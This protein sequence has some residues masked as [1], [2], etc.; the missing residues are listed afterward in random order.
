MQTPRGCPGGGTYWLKGWRKQ[1][2]EDS[3][4]SNRYS[5]NI[6]HYLKGAFDKN[7]VTEFCIKDA[8]SS[9]K[10]D[11]HWPK[12]TYCILKHKNCPA[13]FNS[14]F[15]YWDD[16]DHNNENSH[17]GTLPDGEFGRNTKIYY[18]CRSDAYTNTQIVLPT[19]VPFVLLRF[20]HA[21]QSVHGMIVHEVYVRWDD[22]DSGNES[23]SGGSHPYDD[24]SSGNHALHFCYYQSYIGYMASIIG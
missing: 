22:E 21:C 18:C 4:P 13:G 15:I 5:A 6:N 12:G 7:V 24:G 20:G 9:S 17:G 2:T 19:A 8:W 16:E 10:Y 14:G 3:S 1:D 23:G 11:R